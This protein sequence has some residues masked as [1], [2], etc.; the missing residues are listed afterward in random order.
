MRC[1]SPRSTR[2]HS[3]A[4]TMRGMTSKGQ[5]F[6]MPAS[7]PCTLKVMPLLRKAR[8]AACCRGCPGAAKISS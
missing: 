2:S 6:S 8:S 3:A 4:S 1:S 5:T 7:L